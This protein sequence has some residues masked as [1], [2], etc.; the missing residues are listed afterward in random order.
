MIRAR[1]H[2][3]APINLTGEGEGDF[4]GVE[5]VFHLSI[6]EQLPGRDARLEGNLHFFPD[7][8]EAVRR[9]GNNHRN[10]R[11]PSRETG[12][13]L[14]DKVERV[15]VLKERLLSGSRELHELDCE[16]VVVVI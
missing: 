11:L 16:Q 3:G 1:S 12:V 15:V 10:K 5:G 14:V 9:D 13:R 2:Y 7:R 6:G 4:T 8:I